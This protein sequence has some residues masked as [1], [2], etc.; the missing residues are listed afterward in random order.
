M[1]RIMLHNQGSNRFDLDSTRAKVAAAYLYA[2][3]A[4]PSVW[5]GLSDRSVDYEDIIDRTGPL[6]LRTVRFDLERGRFA[7]DEL[8]ER[9][10]VQAV[11]SEDDP[12]LIIDILAWSARR[13]HLLG[14]FFGHA[15]LLGGDAVLNAAS[16]K[17]APCPIWATP[18][19]WL[20]SSLKGAVVLNPELS[21]PILAKAP[22]LFQC[23]SAAHARWLVE[24]NAVV[25]DK[26]MVP[27][28]T[29]A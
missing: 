4:D 27:Q 11:H 8:S 16:F 21:S 9:A 15:G 13:P 14:T 10:Y 25:L 6:V 28:R 18:L 24:S 3:E 20:Q 22:G 29:A 26:L 19:A 7:I 17:E 5:R 1:Q 23:E 2:D 12:D